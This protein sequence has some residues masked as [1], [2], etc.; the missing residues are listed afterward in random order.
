MITM[1]KCTYNMI[2]MS[3][4]TYN[5]NLMSTQ[6]RSTTCSW[7]IMCQKCLNESGLRMY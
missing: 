5:M 6:L 4:C 2:N 7:M 3:T 1:S